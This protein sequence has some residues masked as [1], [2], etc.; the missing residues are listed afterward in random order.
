MGIMEG[1]S[2]MVGVSNFLKGGKSLK[3][4]AIR[5]ALK[6]YGL[7]M[8]DNAIQEAVIDPVDELVSQITSGKTKNDYSSVEGWLQLGQD[9]VQ[10]G[11]DG[12]LSA[13]LMDGVGAGIN[14]SAY[15]YNKMKNG[16]NINKQDL[17]NAYTDIQN[18]PDID[19]EEHF[20]NSFEYQLQKILNDEGLYTAVDTDGQGN[21]NFTEV[22]GEPIAFNNDKIN[23][24]PVVIYD[25][26]IG[27]Y[28]VIDGESGT[29][30][31]TTPYSKKED[32][33]NGFNEKISNVDKATIDNINNS[34]NKTKIEVLN[35]SNEIRN[36]NNN[37]QFYI[38]TLNNQIYSTKDFQ[39]FINEEI[40]RTT[41]KKEYTTEQFNKI[42]NT[43]NQISDKA[44]YNTNAANSVFD[45]VSNN[46]ENVKVV[47]QSGNRYINSL[48]NEGRV[49]YQ[50]KL[51]NRPYT[52]KK[53]KSIVN[54]AIQNADTTN[55]YQE[56][57]TNNSQTSQEPNA[58]NFYN[59]QSNN[60][61]NDTGY[62]VQDIENVITPFDNQESYSRDELADIW[63]D[64]ISN[65]NYDAYYDE[66]G[67]IERY[68]AIEEEGNNIVVN[69][70]DE[71]DNIVK[72][73]V[74]PNKGGVYYSN[75]IQD[76]LEKVSRINKGGKIN[77]RYNG[78]ETS[79]EEMG[80]NRERQEETSKSDERIREKISQ[81]LR[82]YEKQRSTELGQNV[83]A[84]IVELSQQ[85][86]TE[87]V[88]SKGFKNA[89]GLDIN[90]F[91]TDISTTDGAF[92]SNNEIFLKHNSLS[93]K[94]ATNFK[95][96]HE[97][98]HWL[99]DNR[100]NDWERIYN[101]IDETANKKQ[102]EEYKNV[103]NNKSIFDNMSEVETRE[104]I[105]NEIVSD[106]VGN[107]ANNIENWLPYIEQ[108]ILDEDYVNL[109]AD[110]TLE[111][112]NYGYNIFGTLEQLD[113][114]N[115]LISDIMANIIGKDNSIVM[116]TTQN[117]KS[118]SRKDIE[119]N[120]NISK[121]LS[122]DIDK[123]LRQEYNTKNEVLLRNSTPQLLVDNGIKDLPMYINSRHLLENLI[124]KSKARKLGIYRNDVNYHNL[125]KE[126]FIEVMKA[127]DDPIAILKSISSTGA[128][129]TVVII[130][131]VKN[132]TGEHIIVPVYINGKAAY[133]NVF[134]DTN[135]IKTI[136]GK[137]DI[138]NYV[139]RTIKKD[140][141]NLIYLTKDKNKRQFINSP[142]LQLSNVIN[143][144]SIN[145]ISQNKNS[146]K[147]T[148]NTN[149]S[150]QN[151]K[152]NTIKKSDRNDIDNN[153]KDSEGRTLTKQQQE[154]FKNS[155]ARD[156]N[157][158]LKVFYHGTQ[159]ADRV[160][161][162]FDP[163]RATSGPMAFFTDNEQIAQN[164]SQ[165]KE[166][167]SLSREYDTEYDLFKANNQDL[168]TYWSSL[169]EK[170]KETI[171]EKGN[172]VGL[173][174]DFENIVYAEN[175]SEESFSDEYK[176]RLNREY[177]GNALRALY[178]IWVED[179]NLY[180]EDMSKFKDVL[181]L[182]GVEN[183]DYLDIYKT[184]AKVYKTYLNIQNPLYTN[185]IPKNIIN[186]LKTAAK[187]AKM[188]EMYSADLWDKSN[189][190]PSEWIEKLE[191]DLTN[192]TTH[193]WTV[194]PDWVTNVLKS[195][196]YDGIIDTG[197]KYSNV[198]HQVAIP[199]YS[200][201]IKNVDNATPTSN[202]DI[203]LINRNLNNENETSY[204]K[205]QQEILKKRQENRKEVAKMLK[206]RSFF[207]NIYNSNVPKDF[208]A[209]LIKTRKNYQY[210]PKSN[211]ETLDRANERI[212]NVKNIRDEF[213]LNELKSSEDTAVGELLIKKAIENG[214]YKE[215]CNLSAAL[216]EKLT[217]AGQTVQ[218]A[219]MFK[220]MTAD[221]M[222]LFAQRK[223]NQIN[224]ELNKK[225]KI[226]EI[227]TKKL[228][229][230]IELTEDKVQFING[231]MQEMEELE[232]KKQGN[233]DGTTMDTIER[234]QD[235]IIAK[236]MAKIGEDIPVTMLDKLTSWRNI[237][238][239]LNPKTIARNVVSNS[240][241]SCL[242]NVVD[243]IGVPIDKA[244]S[245]VTGERSLL[246]PNLKTQAKGFKKGLDYAIYDTKEGISTSLGGN[247]YGIKPTKTFKNQLL[248]KLETASYFGVEGLDRPFMQAKYESALE[249]I[250]K[251]DN[252]EF[253][254]DIPT[255]QMKQDA[256]EIA[257]YTT[258]KDK[259]AIS[260][261]LSKVKNTLNLGK[262]IGTADIIGLTYTNI[263]GNLTKKAIDYSPAGL[264]NIY[265]AYVDYKSKKIEGEDTR[266]AQRNLVQ[267]TTRVLIGSG[268]MAVSIKAFLAGVITASGDDEDDKLK[269]LTGE[270]N[271]AINVNAFL[272]WLTGGDTT[273]QDGDL[274]ITYS[275]YEP[276]SSIIAASAEMAGAAKEGQ[277]VGSVVYEGLTTWINTIAEL[278]TLNN[279]SSL[280]EYGDL[281]GTL[282][283]S[284]SQ[285]PSSF[286]PTTCK[287][288]AQLFETNSKSNYSDNWIIKNFI[289]PILQR[290]PGLS[291]TLE[292]N[293]D[294]MGNEEKNYN[295]STGI[296]RAFNVFLNTSYTSTVNM[297]N[298]KQE[299]YDLYLS[300]GLTDHLPLE[301]K[302]SFTYKGE[303]INLTAEEKA[304]YQETLGKRTVEAFKKEMAT[305]DYKS[306]TDE[307]KVKTLK[308][309]IDDINT[310]VRGEVVLEP[311]GLAYDSSFTPSSN[312]L[313]NNGYRLNLTT[314]MQKEYEEVA[315]K[316]Y[317][318]YESHGLYSKEKLEQI[319]SNAKDYAKNYMMKKYKDELVKE[320]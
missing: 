215:A 81:S 207:T 158:N 31:D 150:M 180:G 299:L 196:E 12:A 1:A 216:A 192:N 217:T 36:N 56:A 43:I 71:N 297:D 5:K 241:F 139:D 142:G 135:K 7:N 300:T 258:F 145:S 218:A 280:F 99:R 309:I 317:K 8:A 127:L 292:S 282:T 254:K 109:L 41:P 316:Y 29:K 52:G 83:K 268:I 62:A 188:G 152:N 301:V 117:I 55:L 285:F 274:Y 13:M 85:T 87:K 82:D 137:K 195:N 249:M 28:N 186:D 154:Y 38:K 2:E 15:L 250:M 11:I 172:N 123:I 84:T 227:L 96:Y 279:F 143:L 156:E 183:V 129:N 21:I 120:S 138:S 68:I 222:L 60:Y 219:A 264:Y 3:T 79:R 245:L 106:S 311:R 26:S 230:Q 64:K 97:L 4:G 259:N 136:Y 232:K 75:E 191:D 17:I 226:N 78:Q 290:I 205:E 265:K 318:K 118:S 14:S 263:P 204:T 34:I 291:S 206:E 178:S 111:N 262:S 164:Y 257:K 286:I 128:K 130:T 66:N 271:Y 313:K 234:E 124:S 119:E 40:K 201:Q 247:K 65:N 23:I 203:R 94:K 155:K 260:D 125:G 24:K 161:T 212:K 302:N 276:L 74:I 16:Q 37:S 273:K 281:G 252:L 193:A 86:E 116:N 255:E 115:D 171:R 248:Q 319:E 314:E 6:Y 220:R 103:L 307:E 168:D 141:N 32:A 261:F 46:I 197:G 10:D 243:V 148:I 95:P 176:L 266:T 25:N 42:T 184:D 194:I 237:S 174:E 18:N 30:L 151:N 303:K 308:S 105:I 162:V 19:V 92:Y 270:E 202:E 278:S 310:D 315:S 228:P 59:N 223:I 57:N 199:F 147:N 51:S 132:K 187:T 73:E 166:D 9:M 277:S 229:P 45:T 165:Q 182:A 170:Q 27:Y 93:N 287:Q 253:G 179:G 190:S 169:S 126:T 244:V 235:V 33:I 102:I 238:L 239:L 211:Q 159:R 121:N 133:N 101:L 225:F 175:A 50:Q 88:V 53:L 306:M 80:E 54:M 63:N 320:K 189:I 293:Y 134:I 298:V 131:D 163:N 149:N 304:N 208:K 231:L 246:M 312:S 275:N 240:L 305:K 181:E 283:R 157:G 140:Y 256:L 20:K 90:V 107:W 185:S 160:G 110:I 214:D 77:G 242:E 173:D 48:D 44:I 49:V 58:S 251:L 269:A 89:T 284:L 113:Q 69:Q 76:V 144:A 39:N 114:V 104:Y 61:T 72:S 67:K 146:V 35:K 167:T 289:N 296:A 153:N 47:E 91:N 288:I 100:Y 267:A 177:N 198:E 210:E 213:M 122:S 112:E 295:G 224:E 200:N 98:G 233:I 22:V 108:G 221:G 70:Y 209:E 236:I 272:R 294:T